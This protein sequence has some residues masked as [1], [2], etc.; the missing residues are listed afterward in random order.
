MKKLIITSTRTHAGKTTIGTGIAMN[1]DMECGYF[2]PLGDRP[3]YTKKTLLDRDTEVFKEWM[4]LDV[5]PNDCSIGFEHEKVRSSCKLEGA[6]QTLIDKFEKVS[7]GKEL[8]IIESGRNFTFG[9]SLCMDADSLANTLGGDII[10]VAEGGVRLIID[11]VIAASKVFRSTDSKLAGVIINKVHKEDAHMLDEDIIPAL[12]EENINY[13]GHVPLHP[14][15][16]KARASLVLEKLNAKL[17]AG[18]GGLD[19]RIQK[20]MVG[21][22]SADAALR[23]P[24]FQNEGKMLITGG[25]R[26]DLIL[27]TLSEDTAGIILTNNVLPHPRILSKADELNV[28]VMS[29]PMDTYTTAKMVE[30]IVA[31]LLPD[32][33][34]K[35]ELIKGLVKDG[36]KLDMIL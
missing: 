36:V 4:G 15:L 6:S 25:D 34:D 7:A 31:E 3:I 8:M 10:L 24:D 23:M 21:A 16:E 33:L 20:V 27:V 26:V 19:K 12:E 28:P 22:L 35:K 32:D 14:D 17:V 5:D 11:K 9:S 13:L 18:S 1:S 2:K 29:V 30:H